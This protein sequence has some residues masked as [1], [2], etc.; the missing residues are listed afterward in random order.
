MSTRHTHLFTFGQHVAVADSAHE[1][2][3]QG[4]DRYYWL[5]E[6]VLQSPLFTRLRN[7]FYLSG[8]VFSIFPTSLFFTWCARASILRNYAEF[9][10]R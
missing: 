4:I 3:A 9:R 6:T 10:D 2:M 7:V 1:H 5:R 8:I